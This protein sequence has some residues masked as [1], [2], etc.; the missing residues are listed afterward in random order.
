M[1][2]QL[3]RLQ[4]SLVKMKRRNVII[5]GPAGTGK[6]ALVYE[7]ARRLA[8]GHPAIA[9]MLRDR[10]IF[11]LSPS[12]LRA[13]A[14]VVGAYDERVSSL[15]KLLEAHPKIIMFVDEIHS[16]LQSGMHERGPFTEANEAFK[17]ALGRARSAS[18]G[19]PP[20]AS[21]ATTSPPT[22]PWCAAS[23]S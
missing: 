23:G 5:I 9:P 4:K 17:Q 16:L 3:R 18:S 19:P 6:T 20:P 15:I 22:R 13:G 21:T 12:F 11:E 14:G 7:F 2:T 8:D 1:D 10:D